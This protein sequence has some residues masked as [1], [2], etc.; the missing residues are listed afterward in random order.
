MNEKGDKIM[1]I[2]KSKE[3][4]IQYARLIFDKKKSYVQDSN[5]FRLLKEYFPSE[6]ATGKYKI[7]IIPTFNDFI[8]LAQ[9]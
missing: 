9:N 3:N 7:E 4:G 5:D 1:L 8:I 6:D 2:Y